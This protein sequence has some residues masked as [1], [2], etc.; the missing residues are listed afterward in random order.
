MP[1]EEN[2]V[3]SARRPNVLFFHVDN[4]GFWRVE[5][6][7]RRPVPGNEHGADRCVREGGLPV[8]ELRAGSA[9]HADTLCAFDGTP[10]DPFRHPQHELDTDFG[11]L[12]LRRS[13]SWPQSSSRAVST[14]ANGS[15]YMSYAQVA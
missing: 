15:N 6:L 5:L 8:D 7:Q 9:V 10:R 3:A 11:T 14:A 13:S 2:T 12:L 1:P 4:L